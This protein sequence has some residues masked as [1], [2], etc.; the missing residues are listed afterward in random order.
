M[1]GCCIGQLLSL[2]EVISMPILCQVTHGVGCP[3]PLSCGHVQVVAKVDC[4]ADKGVVIWELQCLKQ[5]LLVLCNKCWLNKR[6]TLHP[7]G[8][9]PKV[10]VAEAMLGVDNV[11]AALEVRLG[12]RA[13]ELLK[14]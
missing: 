7:V 13:E 14:R 4:I 1:L 3:H 10:V 6:L 2:H 8:Q 11:G 5:G 12:A 9:V